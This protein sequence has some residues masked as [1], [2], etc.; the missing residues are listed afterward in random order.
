[1]PLAFPKIVQEYVKNNQNFKT[2]YISWIK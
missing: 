1:M 2:K